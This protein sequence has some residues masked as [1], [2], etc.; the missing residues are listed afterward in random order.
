MGNR[1]SGLHHL[2]VVAVRRPT[3][4]MPLQYRHLPATGSTPSPS[5]GLHSVFNSRKSWQSAC[6]AGLRHCTLRRWPGRIRSLQTGQMVSLAETTRLVVG[7]IVQRQK[8]NTLSQSPE[9]RPPEGGDRMAVC[10]EEKCEVRFLCDLAIILRLFCD[11]LETCYNMLQHVTTCY[12][13]K[14]NVIRVVPHGRGLN[15]P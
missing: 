15:A 12:E 10:Q 8:R 11:L 3:K 4:P 7:G 6:W 5:H 9:Y 1:S 13:R 14:A 2:P